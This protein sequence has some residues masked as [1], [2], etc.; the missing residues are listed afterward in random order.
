MDQ[1]AYQRG[2]PVSVSFRRAQLNSYV[3]ILGKSRFLQAR[4]E[5]CNKVHGIAKRFATKKA[6]NRQ[7]RLLRMHCERPTDRSTDGE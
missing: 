3:L 4:P 7:S 1:F 5:G 6:D 2:Q